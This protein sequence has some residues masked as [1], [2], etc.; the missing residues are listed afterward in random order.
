[1][2]WN[3]YRNLRLRPI[4]G[5]GSLICHSPQILIL[6]WATGLN[7]NENP[8]HSHPFFVPVALAFTCVEAEGK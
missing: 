5:F 7:R 1:M 4:L 2:L 8:I 6:A 3:V